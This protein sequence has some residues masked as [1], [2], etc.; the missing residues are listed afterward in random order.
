MERK[1]KPVKLNDDLQ[2]MLISA[3]RYALERRTYMVEWTVSYITPL[4]PD[5]GSKEL[6]VMLRDVSEWL[7]RCADGKPD[8]IVKEWQR[9]ARSIQDEFEHRSKLGNREEG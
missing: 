2:E 6:G 3:V 1:I 9:F 7:Y 5:F 8:D 4:I